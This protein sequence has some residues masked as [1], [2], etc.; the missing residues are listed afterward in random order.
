MARRIIPT[1]ERLLSRG[2]DVRARL[3]ELQSIKD[4]AINEQY[5]FGR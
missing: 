1:I 4:H 5:F 3:R 2:E